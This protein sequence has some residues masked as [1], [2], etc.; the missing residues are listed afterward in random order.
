MKWYPYF[1]L[2]FFLQSETFGVFLFPSIALCLFP[3]L[4]IKTDFQEINWYHLLT[5]WE[6]RLCFI[7]THTHTQ[8]ERVFKI[9]FLWF[10]YLGDIWLMSQEIDL[11]GRNHFFKNKNGINKSILS[12]LRIETSATHVETVNIHFWSFCFK[13]ACIHPESKMLFK[14]QVVVKKSLKNTD[15]DGIQQKLTMV[16]TYHVLWDF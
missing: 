2:F 1:T 8:I 4:P 6:F 3:F 12:W 9:G 5:L 7:Q 15:L 16:C 14:L 10:H 13:C 11:D